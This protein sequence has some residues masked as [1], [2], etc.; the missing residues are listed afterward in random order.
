MGAGYAGRAAASVLALLALAGPVRAFAAPPGDSPNVL[1]ITVDTLRRDALGWVAGR[2]ETPNLDALALSGFRFPAAVSPVPMTLPAHTSIMT[3]VLPRQH[4]IRDNGQV[5]GAS[6]TTLAERLRAAGY[7]T[8]AFVSGYPLDASF[9]LDRG[10]THYDDT[11]P[12]GIEGWVERRAPATTKAALAWIENA[13]RPWFVWV[14]YF[15]PHEPYDPPRNFWKPGARGAYDGEVSYTDHAI[16]LLLQGANPPFAQGAAA[17]AGGGPMLTVFTAD[18]GEGLGDHGENTH[19]YFVYD[20]TILVPLVFQW[21]GRLASGSSAAAAR[22]VDIAPTVLDLLGLPALATASGR[23]LVARFAG[24]SQ[25]PAAAYVETQLPWRFFGWSPLAALRLDG[26]KLVAAPR[27]E[28]YD[29]TRDAGETRNLIAGVD[30]ERGRARALRDEMR[31]IEALPAETAGVLDDPE[32]LARLQALGY[33]GAG[34]GEETPP[35]G[36]LDPKDR[37]AARDELLAAEAAARGGRVEEALA[38]FARVLAQEPANRF[39]TLRSG[40]VLLKAGRLAAAAE[41]LERAVAADPARAEARF[42]LADALT[43]LGEHARALPHWL[44]LVRLQPRRA[45]HWTNLSY[46]L[47]EN[48]QTERAAAALREASALGEERQLLRA[49]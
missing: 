27:P 14:H 12:E 8:A 9:G 37:L 26:W 17:P 13:P 43:R 39:A 44:E 2:N 41:R 30:G 38:R 33:V 36:L 23:S 28:L 3:G 32:A 7:A 19:G 22:L 34:A 42:A 48:G 1:L 46:S 15:D 29:L 20:S 21:P 40:V 5:L 45:E 18:H 47:R 11:M 31:R 25:P 35:A 16:G 6:S 24:Q 10:F 4:G 49:P